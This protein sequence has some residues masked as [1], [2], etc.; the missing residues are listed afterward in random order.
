MEL[1]NYRPQFLVYILHPDM[2]VA[3]TA[4]TK[5]AHAGYDASLFLDEMSLMSQAK[6]KAPHIIIFNLAALNGKLNDFFAS[7]QKVCP[8]ARLLAWGMQENLEPISAYRPY[9]LSDYV[10]DGQDVETALLWA[11]DRIVEKLL[12][13][14][15]NLQLFEQVN[16]SKKELESKD[17]LI[18]KSESDK[19]ELNNKLELALAKPKP[20]AELV[21]ATKL[22]QTLSKAKS[23]EDLIQ[24]FVQEMGSIFK[25]DLNIVYFKFIPSLYSLIAIQCHGLALGQIKGIGCKLDAEEARDYRK[26]L[27]NSQ[28][29]QSLKALV[30]Q[31][32]KTEEY[33]SQNLQLVNDV[34]GVLVAWGPAVESLDNPDWQL[35]FLTLQDFMERYHLRKRV[36]DLEVTDE[37]TQFY[38]ERTFMLKLGEEIARAQRLRLPVSLVR[39]QVDR[40]VDLSD[41][42]G[43]QG[44]DTVLKS[45]SSIVKKTS[46][47]TDLVYRTGEAEFSFILPHSARKGAALRAE[48]LRRIIENTAFAHEPIK[49]TASFGISEYPSLSRT[50]EEL[51]STAKI[52]LEQIF[53]RGGNK[54]CL[55]AMD[56]SFKP[57]FDVP[58]I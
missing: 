48:R 33:F 53:A 5:L 30:L 37:L 11:T 35:Y 23:K 34:D 40:F 31:A 10:I 55:A 58:P 28:S 15:Q 27:I 19:I 47:V 16:S 17:Q 43:D 42:L 46:R 39:M 12:L 8:E 22:Y 50:A 7:V 24:I 21:Q 49:I 32:F 1:K 36:F 9:G 38:N 52:A 26:T 13:K 45:I 29:C 6:E 4:R 2:A 57:D 44:R 3:S 18:E 25:E 56:R 20:V 41:Y 54:V 14:Y 51:M